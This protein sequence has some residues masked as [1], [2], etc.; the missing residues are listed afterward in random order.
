MN[1][2]QKCNEYFSTSFL[3]RQFRADFYGD[4]LGRENQNTFPLKLDN[5]CVF[6]IGLY[7]VL[8]FL[9]D[10]SSHLTA[11]QT[12]LQTIINGQPSLQPLLIPHREPCTNYE[13]TSAVSAHTSERTLSIFWVHM[14]A[15]QTINLR[16]NCVIFLCTKVEIFW[17]ILV[18]ISVQN[19][20]N[21]C[22]RKSKFWSEGQTALMKLID[23]FSIRTCQNVPHKKG[24]GEDRE[25]WFY[26]WFLREIFQLYKE[27]FLHGIV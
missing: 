3:Y 16:V 26:L 17:Q 13:T 8:K 23:T 12:L 15:K 21:L 25:N 5:G 11:T 18:K 19:F 14:K 24:G 2:F 7:Q 6:I 10:L 20:T 27:F 4:I 1:R 9:I 22:L